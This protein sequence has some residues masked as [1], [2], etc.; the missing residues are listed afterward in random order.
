MM[1]R[2]TQLLE[3]IRPYSWGAFLLA[4]TCVAL[5]TILCV[6]FA[7]LG[8][9]LPFATYFPAVLAAT[10]LAGTPAG[11]FVIISSCLIVLWAYIPPFHHGFLSKTDIANLLLFI[12]SS[13]CIVVI[14]QLY[15]TG[16][17][18]L[19]E[20]DRERDLLLKEL[21]HRGRNTYAVVEAIVR[22]TLTHDRDS[23]D[24]I[25]GRVHAVS[26]A[27]DLINW[28]NTKAVQLRTLLTLEFTPDA[29]NRIITSGPDIELS[30]D[31]TRNLALVI[32][33]LA[34]NAL[35][36]GALSSQDGCVFVE[37]KVDGATIHLR[38]TEQGGPTVLPPHRQGFGTTVMRQCLKSLPGEISF[39]FSPDGLRC[40]MT[41]R[42]GRLLPVT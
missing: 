13:G 1:D 25:S 22:N 28:S 35:K 37:W 20:R 36:H 4:M 16:L 8:V 38:W 7:W 40:D 31:A 32:H 30:A 15:R 23:A 17:H 6:A 12:A 39:D 41:F 10:L 29:K 5:A 26:S 3:Q 14:S 24:A 21:Q 33:E 2:W 11:I 42:G 9:D 34:T 18:E 27:N 19:R